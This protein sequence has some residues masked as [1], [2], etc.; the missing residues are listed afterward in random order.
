MRW[1]V[2]W[3]CAKDFFGIHNLIPFNP[4]VI[5]LL[6]LLGI[7]TT[8]QLFISAPLVLTPLIILL[9]IFWTRCEKVWDD[10]GIHVGQD[11]SE[12][13]QIRGVRKGKRPERCDRWKSPAVWGELE[14]VRWLDR[15][16]P[17]A[18]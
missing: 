10:A 15:F 17:A 4:Q 1:W 12:P 6:T 8:K 16:G 14:E 11:T 7:L 3:T 13:A 5:W 2:V 9:I 18:D